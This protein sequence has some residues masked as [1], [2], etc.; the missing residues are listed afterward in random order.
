MKSKIINFVI[1]FLSCALLIGTCSFA[2]DLFENIS[3][4]RGKMNIKVMGRDINID[5]FIYNNTTYVPLRQLANELDMVVTYDYETSS[6]E[7]VDKVS[8]QI[9]SREIAFLVN[10]QPIRINYF[11][12]LMNYYKLNMGMDSVDAEDA[13]DF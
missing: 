4:V 5:N 7:I 9:M 3:V 2:V 12:E 1:G 8:H 6:V 13:A 11:T 10:G